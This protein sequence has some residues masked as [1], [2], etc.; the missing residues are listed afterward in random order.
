MSL[1]DVQG[2]RTEKNPLKKKNGFVLH[3]YV[4]DMC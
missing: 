3:V 1:K 4:C 2:T